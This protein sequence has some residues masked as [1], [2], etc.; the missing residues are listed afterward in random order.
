MN[1]CLDEENIEIGKNKI[2]CKHKLLPIQK[3]FTILTLSLFLCLSLYLSIYLSLPL[4]LSIYQSIY[5]SIYSYSF[6]LSKNDLINVSGSEK[7]TKL[8]WKWEGFLSVNSKMRCAQ[9]SGTCRAA[10]N[11]R[12]CSVLNF[13]NKTSSLLQVHIWHRFLCTSYFTVDRQKS[14]SFPF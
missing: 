1:S 2:L 11:M 8:E 13:K 6:K 9:E 12:G 4:H 5:L 10:F 3:L 7:R 14:F